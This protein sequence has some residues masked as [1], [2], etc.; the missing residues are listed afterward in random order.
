MKK[1][2]KKVLTEEQ[3]KKMQEDAQKRAFRRK[4]KNIF[5]NSGF[6]Y[7]KSEN[8]QFKISGRD[9]ELDSIYFYKNILVV[10]EDTTCTRNRH[11]HIRTK[12]EAFSIIEENKKDFFEWL[13][14]TF[15]DFLNILSEYSQEQFTVRYLYFTNTEL[16]LT[17]EQK[18]NY[19]LIKFVEPA[20]INYLN[21][22][23]QCIKLSSKYEIFKFL[24]LSSKDIGNSTSSTYV[25]EI[26]TPIIYPRESTGMTNGVRVVSFMMSAESLIK[27]SY[28]MRKDN[29]ENS[30]WLYQRLI[31]LNKIKKI[32]EFIANKGQCFYNNI[33]V[34]LPDSIKFKKANDQYVSVDDLENY[35][36]CKLVIPHEMN[37]VCIID[38]QHRIYAH[39]EGDEKDKYEKKI[40]PLRGKLHLLVTGLI[41]PKNM[42]E[43]DRV[44]IQ[45]EIFLEI[46]SNAKPVQPDVLLN[47]EMLKDPLCDVGIARRVIE[48]LNG[49]ASFLHMFALSALDDVKIKIASII[50][51]A[52][53]YLVTI[54]PQPEKKSFIDF[55]KGDKKALRNGSQKEYENYVDFCA[56]NL[57]IYFSSLKANYKEQWNDK[58]SKIL[59]VTSLNGF[60]LAYNEQFAKNGIKDFDFYLM[61]FKRYKIDFSNDKFQYTSSQYRKFSEEILNKA[62]GIYRD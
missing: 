28:V 2:K 38:G 46:N 10:C 35:E 54:T 33:I 53:R 47:I 31:D 29:W 49:K 45:S 32:R 26:E 11:D 14:T 7:L 1:K 42:S 24:D 20:S 23:T 30:V 5:V 56:S 37:S 59:S 19:P 36:S 8:I 25:A 50:K 57:D 3:K 12:N 55:W 61:I 27:T 60:I 52:L 43:A 44:K 15:P 13:K 62:F 6:T 40:A 41:F 51:F 18:N 4:I 48:N 17:N 22:I 21:K 16:D 58:D 9:I 34:G 39:F